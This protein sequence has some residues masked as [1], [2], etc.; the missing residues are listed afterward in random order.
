MTAEY[1]LGNRKN[2]NKLLSCQ[3]LKIQDLQGCF[4]AF[5]KAKFQNLSRFSTRGG[6]LRRNCR[7]HIVKQTN[8]NQCKNKISH[9]STLENVIN[10][11]KKSPAHWHSRSVNII[12]TLTA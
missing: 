2:G 4:Q 12:V 3:F 1:L 6:T 7:F 11:H 10:Y 8:H 9:R 5:R